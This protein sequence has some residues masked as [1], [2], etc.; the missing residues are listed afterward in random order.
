MKQLAKIIFGILWVVVLNALLIYGVCIEDIVFGF[1]L[2]MLNEL[3]TN[4]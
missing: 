3:A 2:A 4:I 1:A